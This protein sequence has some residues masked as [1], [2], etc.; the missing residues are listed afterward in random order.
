MNGLNIKVLPRE[1][2]AA[3]FERDGNV[4][5]YWKQWAILEIDGLPQSFEFSADEPLPAGPATIDPK[6]FGTMNGRLSL[7][8]VKL[9]PVISKPAAAPA[10]QAK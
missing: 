3:T 5:K 10:P 7:S 9:V 4:R 6:S 2:E 8:R 1:P